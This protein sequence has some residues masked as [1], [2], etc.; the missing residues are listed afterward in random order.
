MK[1]DTQGFVWPCF[2]ITDPVIVQAWREGW[3]LKWQLPRKGSA[4]LLGSTGI[5]PR[6][7]TA[8]V[9]LR[10]SGLLPRK[11]T[12]LKREISIPRSAY[13]W[14][15]SQAGQQSPCSQPLPGTLSFFHESEP[16]PLEEIS[17]KRARLGARGNALLSSDLFTVISK[18]PFLSPFHLPC[19]STLPPLPFHPFLYPSRTARPPGRMLM[20]SRLLASLRS[21]R[22]TP[23]LS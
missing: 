19:H 23:S 10:L 18:E 8:P 16:T 4:H 7:L 20:V 11:C 2:E 15:N 5:R 14:G 21:L 22:S 6:K 9:V 12:D 17:M 3:H 1:S 13:F